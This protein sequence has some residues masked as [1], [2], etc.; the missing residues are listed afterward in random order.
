MAADAF[1]WRFL[2]YLLTCGVLSVFFLFYFNRLFARV[3][4]Y[5]IR[6]YVW[7]QYHVYIDIH[8][9]QLSL[10]G[11]RCFFKGFRY[12]GHNET[13]IINDGYVTWRY[14]LRRV[15]NAE[16]LGVAPT[17]YQ[18]EGQEEGQS[19]STQS[20]KNRSRS[21]LPCRI[22]LKLRG[23]EWF[24]YNRT[25][26]YEA[27]VKDLTANSKASSV[28]PKLPQE[29]SRSKGSH[30]ES[31]KNGTYP[32]G[33][34]I[35]IFPSSGPDEGCTKK[36][37][38]ETTSSSKSSSVSACSSARDGSQ[39]A[40]RKPGSLPFFLMLLPVKIECSKTAVVMGNCNTRSVMTAKFDAVIGQIDARQARLVDLYRQTFELNFEHPVI[41]LKPNSDWEKNHRPAGIPSSSDGN[42]GTSKGGQPRPP[43]K[44]GRGATAAPAFAH[45]LMQMCKL[46]LGSIF[47]THSKN[48]ERN[49]I[50]SKQVPGQGN[51]LGL[52]RY[53][54]AEDNNTL[55]Q[56]R[57]R[58]CEYGEHPT[59]VDS[60]SISMSLHWDVPGT[61]PESIMD[62]KSSGH[63]EN[64]NGDVAPDW[65]VSLSI[66]G[67]LISYGPWA[68]RLRQDLQAMFFPNAYK[69]AVPAERLSPGESRVSTM[70]KITV[71]IEQTTTFMVPTRESSKDWKWK[72]EQSVK[73]QAHKK[74]NASRSY[75]K[76][77]RQDKANALPQGRPYGWLDAELQPDSTITFEMDLVARQG[78]YRNQLDID[79]RGPKMSS[80]VNHG[81][82]LSAQEA[83]ISCDLSYPLGWSDLRRWVIALDSSGLE[84][85]LLRDHIFLLTDIIDD[86][87][88]GPPGDFHT[89]VPFTY[90]M[91]LRFTGFNLHFNANDSNIIN[92]PASVEENTLVTVWAENLIATLQ[93]P[94]TS[95]RPLRNQISFDIDAQNGGFK[96]SRPPWNTHHVFVESSEVATMK[97]L[98]ITG[99]YDYSTSTS[100]EMTDVLRMSVH[101]ISPKVHLYGFLIR[102]FMRIKDNYFGEDIHFRTLEEYQKQISQESTSSSSKDTNVHRNKLSNDLDVILSV[103][104][105]TAEARLPAHLYSSAES[106]LLDIP[107]LGLDL[108]FTN[109]Y[110]DLLVAFSPITLGYLSSSATEEETSTTTSE[111]QIFVDGME[112]KGHRLFG[113]PPTEPTY[114]CNWDFDIGAVSGEC[115]VS[116]IK[117]LSLSLRCFAFT[118]EDAENALQPLSLPTIHDI[119]YL[120]AHVRSLRVWVV[121]DDAA[122]LLSSQDYNLEYNDLARSKFSQRLHM[123]IPIVSVALVNTRDIAAE[124]NANDDMRLLP[125]AYLEGAMELSMLHR[126]HDHDLNRHLQQQHIILHDSRTNRTPWLFDRSEGV[127]GAAPGSHPKSQ[128]PAMPFPPMPEPLDIPKKSAFATEPRSIDAHTGTQSSIASEEDIA[129]GLHDRHKMPPLVGDTMKTHHL[130][131]SE[132]TSFLS[133]DENPTAWAIDGE[134][135]NLL[136]STAAKQNKSSMRA[137]FGA[138]SSYKL[139]YF[140]LQHAS[141]DLSEV[142][143]HPARTASAFHWLDEERSGNNTDGEE[144][145]IDGQQG[146][147]RTSLLVDL[148]SGIRGLFKPQSLKVLASFIDQLQVKDPVSLLDH[149]Q[150]HALE[151]FPDSGREPDHRGTITEVRIKAPCSWVRVIEGT[152]DLSCNTEMDMSCDINLAQYIVTARR[153]N[154]AFSGTDAQS[155]SMFSAH[156]MLKQ[157]DGSIKVSHRQHRHDSM[158]MT[159]ALRGIRLWGCKDTELNVHAYSKGFDL[160][161]AMREPE[162]LPLLVQGGERVARDVCRIQKVAI[163]QAARLR[164]LVFSLTIDGQELPDPPFLTKAS[165]VLRIANSQLRASQSWRLISRLRHVYQLLPKQSRYK[166]RSRCFN[167]CQGYPSSERE[168]VVAIFGRLGM[169]NA[170]DVNESALLNDVYGTPIDQDK[171]NTMNSALRASFRIETV[172]LQ[173]Q[174]GETQSQLQF[175]QF[176]F[177][178][179]LRQLS[180]PSE[181]A[182]SIEGIASVQVYCSKT[183]LTLNFGLLELLQDI[184]LAIPGEAEHT[185]SSPQTS[186]TIFGVN[187]YRM[188]FVLMS[189]ITTIAVESTSVR[190]QCFCRSLSSSVIVTKTPDQREIGTSFLVCVDLATVE[191]FSHNGVVSIGRA[192]KPSI[193]GNL[194][195]RKTDAPS[196]SW[197]L[198]TSCID[199]SLKILED[200]LSLV[201]TADHLMANEVASIMHLLETREVILSR[202]KSKPASP[203]DLTTGKPHI[204][205]F[206][207]SYLISYN[208]LPALSYKVTGKVGRVSIRPGYQR[209]SEIVLDFDL[210][211]HAHAFLGRTGAQTQVISEMVI[212]PINNHTVIGTNPVQRDISFQGTVEHITLDAAAVHALLA[213]LS[214]PEITELTSR[215]H[216]E[217]SRLAQQYRPT[218][219]PREAAS[220]STQAV[221]PFLV[222]AS[223]T[224]VGLGIHTATLQAR[225]RPVFSRFYFE[226]GHV[227][228]KGSNCETKAKQPL[229]FPELFIY[230]RGLEM[231]FTRKIQDQEQPC[232]K[233]I[234]SAVF[235]AAS[236]P[237]AKRELVRAFQVRSS[238]CE[239]VIYT[240][241]ASAVIDILDHLRESF[242][243]IDLTNEVR[244]LQKLRRATLADL[245]IGTRSL[246]AKEDDIKPAALFNAM[247]S[248]ELSDMRVV[249]KVGDS[250]PLSRHRDVEDL[251]L[252]FTKIDLAT[253]R[254]NA[255]RLLIQNFQ[256]QMIPSSQLPTGRSLNSALMP[257]V[258]F[259]V[260]YM[261]TMNDRR[262]AFQAVGKSLDLRLT[263]QFILPA[264]TLRQS[265]AIAVS[266]IRAKNPG[267]GLPQAQAGTQTRDWLKY[268][269]LTSLLVDADFTGAVVYIQGRTVT[270]PDTTTLDALQGRRV[271]QHG[272]YGQFTQDQSGSNTSLRAPGVAIK[273]EYKDAGAMKK[274]LNAEIRVDASSNVLYPSV[275]PLILEISSSV[276]DI[277]SDPSPQ[278]NSAESRPPIAGHRPSA[279]KFIADERLKA[280]DPSVIFR[281]CTLNL[282]LR[283]CK[284]DFSLSCQPIARVAATAQ[285]EHIYV[286]ANTVQAADRGQSFT[287]SG[288][289]S[290]FQTSIKHAYS[291]ESTGGLEVQAVIVSLMNSKHLG[292]TNGISAI[293]QVSPV[294]ISVNAKQSQDF[295]L[296]REIWFPRDIRKPA[297]A[298]TLSPSSEPQ[299]YIVQ[300]YQ[301]ISSA[302]AFP[303]NFTLSFAKLDFQ[304]DL[305]QSLGKSELVVSELWVSSKKSSNWEQNMCLGMEKISLA[306]TGRMSGFV[307]VGGTQIRT[308]IRWPITETTQD[309]APLIQASV[310][311]EAVQ[312]KAAF[313]YQAFAIADLTGMNFFMYNLRPKVTGHDDRLVST[314]EIKRLRAFCT[315]TSASQSLALY[316]AF[317]RLIQE[318]RIAYQA[319]LKD[320][321]KF[322]RRRSTISPL[323]SRETARR[324]ERVAQHA[325]KE[326]LR[327]QTKVMV[328]IGSVNIGVF[329]GTFFDT[330]VFRLEALDASAQFA[331]TVDKSRLH[332]TLALSFGQLQVALSG[333][334][335]SEAPKSLAEVSPEDV[336]ASAARA[337]GGTILKVPKIVAT[338]RTWQSPSSNEIEYIFR[339]AFQGKVDVGWNYSRIDFLRGMWNNHVRALAARLGKPLPQSALQITTALDDN[340]KR[341]GEGQEDGRKKI[342]AVVNVP[343]SSY[344]YTPLKAPVIET[345]Q[346]RDMGEA[347][348]PLEWI[349]LHRERLPNLTHQ[350]II[351]SLLK[352]AKEVDEAYSRILGSS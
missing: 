44:K 308:T 39:P 26:A 248:L 103:T 43:I 327:L 149:L 258:V 320:I 80:S 186:T 190:A 134:S 243:D 136:L 144:F 269:R 133:P 71:D 153:W 72:D 95:F 171:G 266:D 7:R 109:Y 112:I 1:N 319:S 94:L 316:Q 98:N 195:G 340:G 81:L 201:V 185:N 228:L 31:E 142:P 119:T 169:W 61:V 131:S 23:V 147:E 249:W 193:F 24:I 69:D 20:V 101:G 102:A 37:T 298:P 286:T 191:V 203:S 116:F 219:T 338:M 16:A 97:D 247:Y 232:G 74:D 73:G 117:I 302:G 77:K 5:A 202:N 334:T 345:P 129:V 234:A 342:R 208:V 267:Q 107:S 137:R 118:F 296:F 150:I 351:V 50:D 306:S 162:S 200:P 152:Q 352:V 291:R 329:P 252:S 323:V 175:E 127:P 229:K 239:T 290:G 341:D 231:G 68:D 38:G 111:T 192:D 12:H 282:G 284:Q 28:T 123:D 106:V 151:R 235:E 224:L 297:T 238:Q 4:S 159:V 331:V 35:D 241:T 332:S 154:K 221:Q 255:A 350:I 272:R 317:E 179:L 339:S 17:A 120:Q 75:R 220:T 260:V 344:R 230:L 92:S 146:C 130:K 33:S 259:N 85:F 187:Q 222:D 139:P 336:I 158:V 301:Q 9:L 66:N 164:Q 261:S 183:M 156:V 45:D 268:K 212:P 204:A 307:A 91:D 34:N 57:W 14:W 19:R 347:T 10:L 13:V 32:I 174:P 176:G 29:P 304:V 40:S 199:I 84:L 210:K 47:R 110:M 305:G 108:R 346:L 160:K 184:M 52:T 310:N 114:V 113:L 62:G 188:H 278:S 56:E 6:T 314:V 46:F 226:L 170:E 333:V 250:T 167:P 121:V 275:V 285:I 8:A 315:T 182:M 194:D 22:K 59:I 277:I 64:I 337:R 217:L 246:P 48:K 173:L 100:S 157:A 309:R 328:S 148:G 36:E 264:S 322:I 67:G 145:T 299:A 257:E 70:F 236:K 326:S 90:Q 214:H 325:I 233:F 280:A 263:S 143:N 240:K 292:A 349:G 115:S 198:V 300:R 177:E 172:R 209:V 312:I 54:D 223:I 279:S 132:S 348:P 99:A 30:A 324:V 165:Y 335:R 294:R 87:T 135:S 213:T 65:A 60:P 207:D 104:A 55:E 227:H 166:V 126:E 122:F 105:V 93:I 178:S 287:L 313:E 2:L 245:E 196:S 41:Q 181:G 141:L 189:T 276:K 271:P 215:V 3:L 79:I 21:N 128:P 270:D 82:L 83:V 88:V 281:N 295:L 155:S 283:I 124:R 27:I 251:V 293:T 140:R 86:W 256:L 343:Q 49:S 289:F 237:N 138:S 216:Q 321:E 89:F 265:M 273:V 96:F 253:R 180:P 11:G 76:K 311:L 205:L 225:D 206:L 78:G 18:Q 15:R 163:Q 58:S 244:G 218:P 303:W 262:L 25:P 242:G 51:W 288:S 211:E 125:Y 42:H 197:H 53:L 330:Q 254:D 168:D 161:F 318:K 274:S 63:G